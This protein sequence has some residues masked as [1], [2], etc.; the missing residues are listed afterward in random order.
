MS[1]L[2]PSKLNTTENKKYKYDAQ[3]QLEKNLLHIQKEYEKSVD[4]Y[5]KK[6]DSDQQKKVQ[7]SKN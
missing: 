6:F 7:L 4:F 3:Q 5:H 1:E 2:I